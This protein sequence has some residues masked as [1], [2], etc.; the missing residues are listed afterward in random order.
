[1]ER[2]LQLKI[3]LKESSPPVWRRL[4]VPGSTTLSEC[5]EILQTVMGWT[6]K[7]LHQFHHGQHLLT[8]SD[9]EGKAKQNGENLSLDT[10]LKRVDDAITYEY[11]F[12]DRWQHKISLEKILD[13]ADYSDYP[14]PYCMEGEGACPPEDCGG[15]KGYRK[16]LAAR[17]TSGDAGQEGVSEWLGEN[18]NAEI[19]DAALVNKSLR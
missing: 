7:H 4:L 15:I 8:L 19:F 6:N 16:L 17:I 12:G 10:L 1:M 9:E 14:L 13:P 11:D 18:W 5:H 2:I 3:S